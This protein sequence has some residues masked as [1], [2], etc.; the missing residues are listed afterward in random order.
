MRNT[1][2]LILT[3]LLFLFPAIRSNA[4]I[5]EA[6]D[7]WKMTVTPGNEYYGPCVANGMLG[8][9]P[10][11][12]PFKFKY[13]TLNG[14]YDIDKENVDN[15]LD[16]TNMFNL[17][18]FIDNKQALWE[19]EKMKNYTH[20][21]DMRYGR[22]ISSFEYDNSIKVVQTV[23][24]LRHLPNTMLMEIKIT[25]LRNVELKASNEQS[26][27]AALTNQ[28]DK[29]NKIYV[30]SGAIEL[31]STLAQT[32]KGR[33]KL[34]SCF[35][36]LFDSKSP[37]LKTEKKENG[38]EVSSFT[39]KVKK[40]KEFD[41]SIIGSLCSSFTHP[42]PDNEVQRYTI[43]ACLEGKDRLIANHEK[44]WNEL[45]KG[46]IVIEGDNRSQTDVRFALYNLYSF[47]R[48]GS[49]F[50]LSPMGLSGNG[51]MGHVF[52]DCETWM[53][54]PLLM[55]HPEIAKSLLDYRYDRL[56]QAKKNAA[57]HGYKGAMFPWESCESG[58]E[59]TPVW[60]LT[61]PFEHH[62]TADIGIAFWQY[63]QVTHDKLWLKEKGFPV[64]KEVADF[65]LSRVE[66]NSQGEYEIKN[67]VGADEYAANIDNNAFTN[68][69]AIL[70]LRYATQAAKILDL[71]A[72]AMWQEVADNIPIRKF[73]N[74]VTREYEN[75]D[76]QKIKQADA[77][78]LT[79][80]LCLITDKESIRKDLEYYEPRIDNGPAM[81]HSALAV[82]Y[83]L[84]GD[85]KRSFELFQRGYI[86]NQRVPYGA[87]AESI[88]GKNP[89]FVTAAGGMLQAV[90]FGFGGM[91]LTDNGYVQSD[92]CLPLQWKS[93]TLKG[94]GVE[95]KTYKSGF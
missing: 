94:V 18:L 4:Q 13:I 35:S 19:K 65:W 73:K 14:L 72:D 6:I 55:L 2:L 43:F 80:P 74:G 38:N 48:E 8:V 11:E 92:S 21:I 20:T 42:D 57:S 15:R 56:I 81:S 53:F 95:K 84:L 66:K 46:D 90:L 83:C 24:A 69:A 87:L 44:A 59:D 34:A 30:S 3:F 91:R 60:A 78:L 27:S 40:G 45:W 39:V 67:V 85:K 71:P 77:N 58:F 93:L 62:I 52:W 76:G 16:A 25:A 89:Y 88:D 29:S 64:L 1:N 22:F 36:Y 61:G 86:P 47:V 41:Y 82:G 68:G 9:I 10:S 70:A 51:Y 75:Y 32:L 37:E 49:G 31:H 54:P 26:I 7:G 79:F 50:S 12:V 23:Y 5:A 28:I 63:Y 33:Y 17:K